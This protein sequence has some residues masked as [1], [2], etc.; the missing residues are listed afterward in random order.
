MGICRGGGPGFEEV[1]EVVELGREAGG[2]GEV[3]V[4]GRAAEADVEEAADD[5][6]GVVVGKPVEVVKDDRLS[7]RER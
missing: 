6:G 5:V 4:V 1:G 7:C 2:C 3:E